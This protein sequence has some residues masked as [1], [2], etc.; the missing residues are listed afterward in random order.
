M[1][2]IKLLVIVPIL[3]VAF[4]CNSK[5]SKKEGIDKLPSDKSNKIQPELTTLENVVQEILTTSPRYKILTAGL[6]ETV[7][8]N[9]GSSIGV[10]LERSPITKKHSD[11]VYSKTYDFTL[12]EMYSDRKLNTIRFSF[13]PENKQLYEFDAANDELK[14]I[15]FDKSLLIKYNSLCK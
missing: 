2:I 10:N 14:P 6:Y 1:K 11:W 5:Q 15:E 3:I 8:K 4:A 12:Y 7:V 9:G 13:D